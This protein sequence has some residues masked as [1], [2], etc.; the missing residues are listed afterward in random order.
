MG[1]FCNTI[2]NLLDKS[3][4]GLGGPCKVMTSTITMI[5]GVNEWQIRARE[6]GRKPQYVIPTLMRSIA[7]C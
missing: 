1:I 5:N 7:F 3:S 6:K 4:I 2:L